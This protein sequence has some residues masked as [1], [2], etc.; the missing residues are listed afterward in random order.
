MR[1][2]AQRRGWRRLGLVAAA[3][4]VSAPLAASE[5]AQGFLGFDPRH[6]T[7]DLFAGIEAGQIVARVVPNDSTFCRVWLTN[8]TGKPLNVRLPEALA[9]VPVLAQRNPPAAGKKPNQSPQTLG[10]GVPQMGN[11]QNP[12]RPQNNQAFPNPFGQRPNFPMNVGPNRPVNAGPNGRPNL[13]NNQPL[14]CIPPEKTGQLRLASVCLDHGHP[15]PKP[16]IAYELRPI[17]EIASQAEVQ[18]LCRML[19]RG[20]V[21]QGVAQAAAWHLANDL[22]W[23][24]LARQ[25]APGFAGLG[26]PLFSSRDLADARSAVDKATAAVQ[27]RDKVADPQS[28][29]SR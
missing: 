24:K 8:K 20:E 6:E 14:F 28:L 1:H 27:D 5:V 13:G 29:T 4:L 25:R 9:A 2:T 21:T 17:E 26:K 15:D 3:V 23:K 11:P 10:V 7:V 18:E 16:T 19:G 22:T 12:Q